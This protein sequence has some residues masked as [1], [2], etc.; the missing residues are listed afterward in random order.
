VILNLTY[1]SVW[2]VGYPLLLER[3]GI[4]CKLDDL[5]DSCW[6]DDAEADTHHHRMSEEDR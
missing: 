6:D 2:A 4:L 3:K 1:V 5:F